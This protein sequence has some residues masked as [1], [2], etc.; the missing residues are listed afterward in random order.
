MLNIE[1]NPVGRGKEDAALSVVSKQ[2]AISQANL[3]DAVWP[4]AIP[5]DQAEKRFTEQQKR[6]DFLY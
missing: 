3:I 4:E 5:F 6:E 2:F 1:S